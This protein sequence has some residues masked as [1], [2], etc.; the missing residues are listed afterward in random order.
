MRTET[1]IVLWDL[2]SGLIGL[3]GAVFVRRV[4]RAAA[5]VDD[6]APEPNSF[7]VRGAVFGTLSA[8]GIQYIDDRNV[9]GIRSTLRRRLGF[10]LG[11]TVLQQR[12]H[13]N[14]PADSWSFVLGNS[15]GRITYRIWF[16]V[17]RPIPEARLEYRGFLPW[18]R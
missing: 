11:W 7:S 1:R 15:L 9:G 18:R 2:L 13:S 4:Q 12:F 16:G 17:V 8:V 10:T 5:E 14:D 3:S 6:D